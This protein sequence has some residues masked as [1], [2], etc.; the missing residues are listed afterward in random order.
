MGRYI[1]HLS[2]VMLALCPGCA[3]NN[4]REQRQQE[5]VTW[6]RNWFMQAAVDSMTDRYGSGDPNEGYGARYPR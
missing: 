3:S 1:V 5:P 2:F 4:G 6:N